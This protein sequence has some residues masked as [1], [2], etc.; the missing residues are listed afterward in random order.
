MEE[1]EEHD[2]EPF[3]M[4]GLVVPEIRLTMG[5]PIPKV[6]IRVGDQTYRYERSVPI[7]GHSAVLPKYL[8]EQMAAGKSVLL[9]ERPDRLYV[10]FD[11]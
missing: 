9:I 4:D 11:S 3:P 10:Y 2:L 1:F 5:Q 7:K 6:E 8:R